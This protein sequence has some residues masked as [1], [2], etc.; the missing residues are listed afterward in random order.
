MKYK[1]LLRGGK[2]SGVEVTKQIRGSFQVVEE[3][4]EVVLQEAPIR[5]QKEYDE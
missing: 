4:E 3:D 1:S 5:P 2:T